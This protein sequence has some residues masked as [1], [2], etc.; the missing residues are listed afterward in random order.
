MKRASYRDAIEWIAGN[1]SAGDH[2][3]LDP[4]AAGSLVSSV[5][6]ADIFDVPSDKVGADIVRVR[7]KTLAGKGS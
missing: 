6:V 4:E 2:D 7:K 1:D 5:L 3:A